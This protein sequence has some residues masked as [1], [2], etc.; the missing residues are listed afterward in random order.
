MVAAGN[1]VAASVAAR[2]I[3]RG[4][5]N[6]RARAGG[7]GNVAGDLVGS[8]TVAG[9]K[10]TSAGERAAAAIGWGHPNMNLVVAEAGPISGEIIGSSEVSFMRKDDL[11][12]VTTDVWWTVSGNRL[13]VVAVTH[14]F[15][16]DPLHFE[17]RLRYTL[18]HINAHR[19]HQD[20][21]DVAQSCP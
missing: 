19:Q 1:A 11:G 3:A 20:A 17:I 14:R 13:K 15:G 6:V 16:R 8:H 10:G 4:I 2:D 7:G 18:A 5:V 9:A 21:H 12:S